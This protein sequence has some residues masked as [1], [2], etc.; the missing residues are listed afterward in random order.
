MPDARDQRLLDRLNA[1][2]PTPVT[3]DASK[4]SFASSVANQSD[5]SDLTSR[6]A[7]LQTTSPPQSQNHSARANRDDAQDTEVNGEDELSLD[8]LLAALQDERENIDVKL[9]RSDVDSAQDLMRQARAALAQKTDGAPEES[10]EAR[11]QEEANTQQTEEDEV[12]EYIQQALAAAELGGSDDETSKHDNEDDV[13]KDAD[14][15]DDDA[16]DDDNAPPSFSLPSAPTS[17]P[18][19]PAPAAPSDTLQLPSTPTS[20]PQTTRSSGLTS[21]PTKTAH[22]TFTDEEIATWCVICNE[23]ATVKCLSCE[24][25]LYCG[26]CWA[27]GHTGSDAGY[28]E[29]RHKAV[30]FVRDTKVGKVKAKR[31][32]VG[33]S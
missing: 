27:E 1:L 3:L 20:A 16:D 13:T 26:E 33:A 12:D 24:G 6:F 19:S 31:R 23:D 2:R 28:E 8:D 17:L 15:A 29:R 5:T 14:Q 25:D 22:E 11:P 4:A 7:R 9:G 10:E 21:T 30:R 32:L 18:S